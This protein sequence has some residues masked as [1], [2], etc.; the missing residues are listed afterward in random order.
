MFGKQHSANLATYL[1]RRVVKNYTRSLELFP[2]EQRIID[3]HATQFA[4]DV[5]DIAIGAGRTTRVLLPLANSYVGVD[6]APG[7]IES[8]KA[9]FPQAQLRCID[10][11]AV[12]RLFRPASF[13]AILISFNGIDYISWEDRNT[14]LRSLRGMLRS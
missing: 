14:L 5:L 1:N 3:L 6:F 10:M 9:Q 8:A 11:R 7:M 2:A 12:P 13:D 4:G